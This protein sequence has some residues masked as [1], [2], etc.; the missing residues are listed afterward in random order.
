MTDQDAGLAAWVE[1][2]RK[3]L[4]SAL[5]EIGPVV[6]T[7]LSVSGGQFN[8][9]WIAVD[10]GTLRIEA[11]Q[12]GW[13]ITSV[14]DGD[15]EGCT[16]RLAPLRLLTSMV[17]ALPA[18][19]VRLAFTEEEISLSSERSSFVARFRP[20]PEELGPTRTSPLAD[21]SCISFVGPELASVL[22]HVLP[23]APTSSH[24]PLEDGVVFTMEPDASFTIWTT[25][26]VNSAVARLVPVDTGDTPVQPFVVN[27]S[28]AG[29]IARRARTTDHVQVE[30][31]AHRLD[32]RIGT[33]TIRSAIHSH[34]PADHRAVTE[35]PTLGVL[36]ISRRTFATT[37]R[38]IG[39]LAGGGS[40]IWFELGPHRP[41][42][43][44]QLDDVGQVREQFPAG[45]TGPACEV[46][47][48][49]AL[50]AAMVER[51]DDGRVIVEIG[52]PGKA[53][54][55]YSENRPEN[56]YTTFPIIT[57]HRPWLK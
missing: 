15:G 12:P 1:I 54:R 56:R 33:T 55:I 16:E 18:G 21:P 13:S 40:T 41:I 22:D 47:F 51:L 26:R 53:V 7:Q 5:T 9:G 57:T 10:H 44:A 48:P 31:S 45:Y 3:A 35:T 30:I 25:D 52:E 2:D 29:W 43:R 19:T 32:V 24:Y 37:T 8:A 50:I 11:V 4:H 28:H 17:A 49:S 27:A 20:I 23:V 46:G 39:A 34:L 6:P 36:R 14:T 42:A 38:R